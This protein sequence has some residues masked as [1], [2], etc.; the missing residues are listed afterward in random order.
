MLETAKSRLYRPG[1][2]TGILAP[3]DIIGNPNEDGDRE[4][5]NTF[6]SLAG[7]LSGLQDVITRV[8]GDSGGSKAKVRDPDVFDGSDP[9]KLQSFLVSLQLVFA[10][11]PQY[12]TDEKK[13]SYTLSYLGGTAKEW[14]EPDVLDPDPNDIPAWMT[15]FQY[16]VKELTDNFGM[17]DMEGDAKEHL[18]SLRMHKGDPI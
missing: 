1:Q 2:K 18:G 14:F 6:Q 9:R 4:F 10:D 16:L 5:I 11:R 7:V 3:P 17:Y 8:S 15:S 13:I 12:F